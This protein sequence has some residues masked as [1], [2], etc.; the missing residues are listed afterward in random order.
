MIKT[1]CLSYIITE[2]CKLHPSHLHVVVSIR[3]P[4]RC[5]ALPCFVGDASTNDDANSNN[6]GQ[7]NR[8]DSDC[9]RVE[10]IARVFCLNISAIFVSAVRLGIPSRSLTARC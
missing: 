6:A 10:E 8:G 4:R 2:T 1:H 5:T 7:R 3:L 9:I